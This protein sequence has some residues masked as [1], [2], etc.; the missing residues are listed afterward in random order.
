MLIE[1]ILGY[2]STWRILSLLLE[3]PRKPI[4]RKELFINTKLGNAPLSNGLKKLMKANIIIQQKNGK[5]ESYYINQDNKFSKLIFEIWKTEKEEVRQL[6]YDIKLILSE[7]TRAALDVSDVKKIIL[8]GSWAKGTASINSDIDLALI[9]KDK[10]LNELEL[11]KV[12]NNLNNHYK[13]EIQLHCFTLKSFS[14]KDKL[15]EEIKT[16]GIY[17]LGTNEKIIS[18]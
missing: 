17:I 5:K 3:T 2:K 4:S 16:D 15:T 9:F 6:D 12:V 7:F 18:K 8:F 13:K 10:I 14:F 1:P 11:T